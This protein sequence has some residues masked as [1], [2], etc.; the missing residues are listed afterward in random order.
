MRR[1]AGGISTLNE[2]IAQAEENTGGIVEP[3]PE[4]D[5]KIGNQNG[6]APYKITYNYKADGEVSYHLVYCEDLCD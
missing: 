6:G 3:A 1:P 2:W 5:G 4:I